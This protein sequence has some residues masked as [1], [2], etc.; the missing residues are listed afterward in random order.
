MT[1]IDISLGGR[2]VK[3]DLDRLTPT[4]RALAEAIAD[5]PGR[6]AV[7]IWMEADA[8]ISETT[9]DWRSWFS[10]QPASSWASGFRPECGW[11][12][13]STRNQPLGSGVSTEQPVCS[14]PAS[15]C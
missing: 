10:H 15:P 2:A 4:A 13:R 14:R 8:P 7:D 11:C 9:P 3:V 6:A 1:S 12:R 5:T